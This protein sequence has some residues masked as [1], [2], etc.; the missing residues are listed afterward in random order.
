MRIFVNEYTKI[1]AYAFLG[2]IF[3]YASFYFIANIYHYQEIRKEVSISLKEND[4][5]VKIEQNLEKVKTVTEIN[6]DSYHGSVDSFSLLSL[7][8][9]LTNC[10]ESMNNEVFQ[11]YGK[12]G[13]INI[14]DVEDFRETV[15]NEVI[16]TCLIENMYS[17]TSKDSKYK[18]LES[19]KKY[20][21]SE[22]E[23]INQ[24]AE[25]INKQLN[26]NSSFYF[27]TEFARKNVYNDVY[28]SFQYL[29]DIYKDTSDL[30]LEISD[31]YK[32]EVNANV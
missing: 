4:T 31:K 28:D 1:A 29:L 6:V 21:K 7:R 19:D 13:K 9:S 18:F 5:Y 20:I 2:I 3:S 22:I 26:N 32:S 8:S 30:V 10:E 27:N 14:K 17:L 16:N 12:K 11:S 25:I 24:R 15:V 23:S